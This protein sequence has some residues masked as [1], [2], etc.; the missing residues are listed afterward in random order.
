MYP[1]TP[2][3]LYERSHSYDWSIWAYLLTNRKTGRKDANKHFS[4]LFVYRNQSA[5]LFVYIL[6][7]RLPIGQLNKP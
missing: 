7:F 6:S 4:R 2:P 5:N 3:I 1:I